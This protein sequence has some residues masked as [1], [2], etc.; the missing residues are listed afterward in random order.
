MQHRTKTIQ[1]VTLS[2]APLSRYY[3]Y[4]K[5]DRF[6]ICLLG[7]LDYIK[8]SVPRKTHFSL[9]CRVMESNKFTGTFYQ[10]FIP[11]FCDSNGD[12]IGDLRGIMEKLDYLVNLGIEGIWLSP[13][14]P[15]ESYHKYDVDDYYAVAPEYGTMAD[16]EALILEAHERGIKILMD[17]VLNCPSS[18]HPFFRKALEDQGSEEASWFWFRD[19]DSTKNFKDDLIWNGMPS[20]RTAP[21]GRQYIGIYASVMPDFNFDSQSLREEMKKV[22]RFWLRKGVDGFRLDSAMHLYSSSEVEEGVSYHAKNIAWWQEFRDACRKENPGCYLV[23]EVWTDSETRAP[24]YKGLDSSF[25]FYLGSDIAALITGTLSVSSLE[26]RL[27]SADLCAALAA[28]GYTD[29]P[30]L[31][32]HDMLRYAEDTG[33]SEKLLKLS[34]AI[35]LTLPGTPF[36]YYGEE[37]GLK[38]EPGDCCVGF[39]AND[40]FIRSRSAFPWPEK[41][42]TLIRFEKDYLSSPLEEQENDPD[43]LLSFYKA[44]IQM[45]RDYSSLRN[46]KWKSVSPND[47]LL[48]YERENEQE[49]TLI[50]H[51]ISEEDQ[52][53][54]LP[55]GHGPVIYLM[56]R[57]EPANDSVFDSVMLPAR[58]SILVYLEK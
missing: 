35:Y 20:W 42:P 56:R 2:P 40:L 15:S 10:I 7:S 31:S 19:S 55:A 32:N 33:F 47:N 51:N 49:K 18:G 50:V 41:R 30:F 43:S 23:G 39:P 4:S 27:A 8:L 1:K 44:L 53:L 48:A 58:E 38:P 45:R 36:V 3:E 24:Y 57:K 54:A 11:S 12:G 29:S 21:N 46:G 6:I 14:H 22:A 37:L 25:H 17:L 52:A 28:P 9:G 26:N 13:L 34:A 16:F 5:F